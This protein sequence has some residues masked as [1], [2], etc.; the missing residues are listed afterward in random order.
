MNKQNPLATHRQE[1]DHPAMSQARLTLDR[2]RR[3]F[4]QEEADNG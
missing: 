2:A 3:A 4:T 1:A